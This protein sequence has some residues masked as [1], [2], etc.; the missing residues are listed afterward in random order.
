MKELKSYYRQIARELPCTG[1]SKKQLLSCIVSNIDDYLAENPNADFETVRAHFG[2]PQQIASAYIDETDTPN[3]LH[4]IK[5][6]KR[7]VSAVIA[8]AVIAIA[9]WGC[10]L[11]VALYDEISASNGYYEFEIGNAT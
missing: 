3:L 2:T 9:L 6:R 1:K 8:V 4:S 5:I 7:I 10:V 11:A